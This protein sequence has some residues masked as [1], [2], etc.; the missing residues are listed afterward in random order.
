MSD[1]APPR[2]TDCADSISMLDLVQVLAKRKW[3]ITVI[4]AGA[5]LII[6]AYVALTLRLPADNSWNLLPNVFRPQVEVLVLDRNSN[7]ALAGAFGEASSVGSL[8]SLLGV[9]APVNNSAALAMALL[10]GR[11]IHDQI[12]TEFDFAGRYGLIGPEGAEHARRRVDATLT[13]E[14]SVDANILTISYEGI[15]AEL[16]TR[17]LRRAVEILADR[18]RSLTMETVRRKKA[19]LEER[20]AEVE[21]ERDA[22][23]DALVTF[24]QQYGIVDLVAQS[25]QTMGLIAQYRRE[26]LTQE[27]EMQ[28][29]LEYRSADDAGVVQIRNRIDLL[30]QL[31]GQLETGGQLFGGGAIPQAQL[32]SLSVEYLNLTNELKLQEAIYALLRQQYETVR[33]EE[34]DTS[35][36]FQVVEQA[37]VPVLR[38]RPSRSRVVIVLTV[39]AFLVSVLVAFVLES[40]ERAGRDPKRA[41]KLASIRAQLARG[42]RRPQQQPRS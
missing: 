21:D 29:M 27:L 36:I 18:F 1:A 15:D 24:Q 32:P 7:S 20:L 28:R 41:E 38:H 22:A 2:P 16:A 26:R 42:R 4:T 5:G 33:I 25:R 40:L 11:T 9:S 13:Y 37:E 35:Q 30:D 3:L 8:A 39:T 23:Q 14:Y 17:I 19:F 6:L 31:I 10:D 12:A 34:T